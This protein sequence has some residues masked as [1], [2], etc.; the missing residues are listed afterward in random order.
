[1]A[2]AAT[3]VTLSCIVVAPPP[4]PTPPAADVAFSSQGSR[5]YYFKFTHFILVGKFL[6]D[7][8]I[9]N[10]QYCAVDKQTWFS[11]VAA[12]RLECSALP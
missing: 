3:I 12:I 11:K 1:M 10:T 9:N 6:Y 4:P 2:P 8:I 7:S 5:F